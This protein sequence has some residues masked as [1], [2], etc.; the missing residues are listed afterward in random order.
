MVPIVEVDDITGLGL[1]G[2]GNPGA[3][4]LIVGVPHEDAYVFYDVIITREIALQRGARI[5]EVPPYRINGTVHSNVKGSAEAAGRL[6]ELLSKVGADSVAGLLLSETSPWERDLAY[7]RNF[8][9]F[10]HTL[11]AHLPNEMF[12]EGGLQLE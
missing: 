8:A 9:V 2:Y 12:Q 7:K 6:E 10:T 5:H 4:R 11:I 3:K 1:Q